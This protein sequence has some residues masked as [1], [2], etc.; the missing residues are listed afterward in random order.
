MILAM[1]NESDVSL[2]TRNDDGMGWPWDDGV[3]DRIGQ[4]RTGQVGTERAPGKRT[5]GV[6]VPLSQ[7]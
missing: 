1:E 6:N 7:S 5:R 4:N 2:C 3:Q